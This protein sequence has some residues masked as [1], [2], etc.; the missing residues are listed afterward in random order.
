MDIK[1][2]VKNNLLVRQ[3]ILRDL[4][5]RGKTAKEIKGSIVC[6]IC[7][8]GE[9]RYQIQSNGHMRAGCSTPDCVEWIE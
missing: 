9:V 4:W 2:R 1:Q 3:F 6:P 7:G 5:V 8:E